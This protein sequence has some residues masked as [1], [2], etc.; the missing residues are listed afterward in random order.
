MKEMKKSQIL[1]ASILI[2]TLICLLSSMS[3]ASAAG[4]INLNKNAGYVGDTVTVT[5]NGFGANSIVTITFGGLAQNTNPAQINCVMGVFSAIFSVPNVAPGNYIV[6]AQDDLSNRG[7]ATFTVM[8][9]LSVVVSPVSWV[10][11]DGQSKT[12]I[13]TASGGS[14]SYSSYRWYVDGGVQGGQIASSFNFSPKSSGSYMVA[15]TVTDSLGTTSAQS[16]ASVTVN[17][18]LAAPTLTSSPGRIDQGQTSVLSSSAVSTGTAPYVYQWLQ[19]A[20][21]AG[22]YSSI[23]GATLSSYS[24]VTSGST[25][26]GTWSFELQVTDAAGAPPVTS[27]AVSVVVNSALVAPTVSASLGTVTQ[28]QTSVL[29]SSAVS[30]GTAPYV[31]QWLQRAPGAGSYSSI[32]GATLSSYSFV[33]SGSTA[34]GTWSFELQV[35]DAAGAPPV[36]SSAVSVVVNSA[37]VAPTVSAS[38]GTVTQGQ[39]S[40]LSSSAVSTGTAPYVYQWL[41][42]APGAGSYSS[43]AGATLSSY[44]FVTSGS[45]ATGTW[46]FELQVTDAVSAVVT[47][48]PVSVLVNVVPTVTVSPVSWVMDVGQAKTFTAT[49]SGGSG[50]YSSYHWYVGGVVQSGQST[51]TFSYSPGSVGSYSITVTV[52]DSLG[53]TSAMSSA[54]SVS[55]AA[56]PTVV[57]SP[58][59]PVTLDVGQVRVFTATASGG[60]G[61]IHFQWYVDGSAVGTDSASYSYTAAGASHSVTCK[62]TDSA[63]VP[64]T[65]AA[66]NAVSI[67]VNPALVAPTIS[68]SA[69]TIN[70]GQ[71]STLSST[72]VSTG[73]PPYAYKWLQRAPGGS[74]AAVGSNSPSFSFAATGAIATGSWSFILQV[75]DNAGAAVNSS[76][77]SVTV[78]IASLDH[79]IFSTVGSQVAGT[80]FTITIT[81][82][83][84]FNSTITNYG[85]TNILSVSTG[86]TSPSTTGVFSSGV[87]TGA[88]MVTGAGS[89]IWLITSGSGMSGTSD[90]FSVN[91]SVF[92]RFYFSS[93]NDQV[94]GSPFSI[95]IISKDI[96]NNTVTSYNGAPSLTCSAGSINPRAMD[97]FLD[98]V[99]STSVTVDSAEFKLNHHRHRW[100]PFCDQQRIQGN[101]CTNTYTNINST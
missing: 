30:T 19:R 96:Y 38:L 54:A 20:P 2:S 91:P 24:F 61:T 93:V 78:N 22:S 55:V 48:N 86:T 88:V 62:V 9:P 35:T 81:A 14:G 10:M 64:V 60:S 33:T 77:V 44:S 12:I 99:G 71:S 41:Q 76:A 94:A 11:D 7:E 67:T 15:A 50:S 73:T 92:D 34:T 13:A 85:G 83:N 97:A 47:S 3:P 49:A 74:Y 32:A 100:N 75:T 89:G 70:Q 18:A 101:K 6:S 59:G 17:S 25:A 21:G 72:V 5:G 36:T 84:A 65:S 29:S 82:K 63:S 95:T 1:A 57:I 79:F 68:A 31:Y 87:W 28:G 80:P 27:S 45:T 69:L 42:R 56:S 26:T 58:V 53:T 43:I 39:T 37:L 46:S 40:V 23:A 98:G 52:T 90:T 16:S 4:M 51:S 8:A 66:S